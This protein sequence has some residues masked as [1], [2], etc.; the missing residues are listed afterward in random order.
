MFC[1]ESVV[2]GEWIYLGILVVPEPK[3]QILLDDLLNSRCGNPQKDKIWGKCNPLCRYHSK[4]DTEV[5]FSDISK[6]KDK[7]FVADRWL[8]YFLRDRDK[9]YFHILGIDLT[10]LDKSK[11][12]NGGQNI[13]YNR[14]F[15]TAILKPVKTY[16]N[17]YV[18]IFID[19]IYHDEN[20]ALETHSYFPWHSI[21]SIDEQ[22]GKITFKT[23]EI[24]FIN[25]DHKDSSNQ[26]SNFIQFID[27]LLGC[28]RN[29]IDHFSK[30]DDKEKLALKSL[31]II[32]RLIE[33]PNNVSSSYNYVGRQKIEFFPKHDLKNLDERS[34]E[35][36][37]KRMASFYAGR[38]LKIKEKAQLPLLYNNCHE[39]PS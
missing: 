33:A 10:K 37:S 39:N 5:R 25:S 24:N 26:Y 31:P 28:V 17:R 8:D 15:R 2:I 29:C 6:S 1:D 36:Q 18:K 14:F 35:Y 23:K 27:L 12:G 3:E 13:I 16:F 38:K 19:S 34:I 20:K 32:E 22:D 30:D 4:N 11:F 7:Y 9:I 21:F